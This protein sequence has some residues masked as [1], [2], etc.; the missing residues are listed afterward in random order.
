MKVMVD[1]DGVIFDIHSYIEGLIR[2]S[3]DSKYSQHKILTY[4]LN[5][6]LWS[7]LTDVYKGHWYGNKEFGRNIV[8]S[9]TS[10]NYI[11]S[12]DRELI[13]TAFREPEVFEMCDV[14]ESS[15][16][17][18]K[19][20][21]DGGIDIV[22]HTVSLSKEV[23]EA[24]EKRL[25]EIFKGY[26]NKYKFCSCSSIHEKCSEEYDYVIEDCLETLVEFSKVNK[27]AYLFLVN[28]SYNNPLIYCEYE[29]LLTN[30]I[31]RVNNTEE[32][33]VYIFGKELL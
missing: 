15:I 14:D 18:I 5:K 4:D 9:V 23:K 31:H 21:L 30:R 27:K 12:E 16:G 20:L 33:L 26:E 29:E 1:V 22:F 25:K 19:S 24:K 11:P 28:K 32:A 2:D 7:K 17:I 6:S 10:L 3:V 13:M 8:E